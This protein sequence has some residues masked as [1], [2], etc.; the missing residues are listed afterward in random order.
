MLT[1]CEWGT[2]AALFPPLK[3][4]SELRVSYMVK[5]YGQEA[6]KGKVPA[7]DLTALRGWV[8]TESYAATGSNAE[9]FSQATVHMCMHNEKTSR[10]RSIRPARDHP[11]ARLPTTCF[12][13][14]LTHT[15]FSQV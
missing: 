14:P 6:S 4:D 11:P 9:A 5:S 15:H 7:F 13:Q 10:Q 3:G 1:G 8:T 2:G 12:S